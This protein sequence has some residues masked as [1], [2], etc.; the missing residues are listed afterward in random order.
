MS[1]N[2]MIEFIEA[3]QESNHTGRGWARFEY[4]TSCRVRIYLG[5]AGFLEAAAWY[6]HSKIYTEH[7]GVEWSRPG[8]STLNSVVIRAWSHEGGSAGEDVISLKKILNLPLQDVEAEL[9]AAVREVLSKYSQA[10]KDMSD[11][12]KNEA[13]SVD[14]LLSGGLQ[15]VSDNWK[16]LFPARKI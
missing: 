10:L 7:V 11:R 12:I 9:T 15:P 4:D 8:P 3:A 2:P 6:D 5:S 1:F 13:T 16:A 14:D